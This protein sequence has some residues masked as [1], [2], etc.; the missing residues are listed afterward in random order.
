MTEQQQTTWPAGAP[1]WVDISVTDIGR[2]KDFYTSVLGW[3]FTGGEA[4]FG[5]YTNATLD[6]RAV[7]G[8][9]PPMEGQGEVPNLWT[10]Y[11]AVEDSADVEQQ[12]AAA[13]GSTTMPP[14]QV[15]SFG[16]M[17]IHADPTGAVFGTWQPG[18]HRGFEVTD[19]PGAI[20]WNEAMVGDFER[21]KEFYTQI[22]G[23]T[24]EDMSSEEMQYAIFTTPGETAGRTGGIGKVDDGEQPY[25]SVVF[26][27]EDTD[28]AAQRVTAAGG[29]VS[30]EP[31]DFEFGRLA[32]CAGPDG[33]P[34]GIITDPVEE[35]PV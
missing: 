12:I 6:G 7:A 17:G 10:V 35:Q 15:G 4:E 25:W 3:D 18:G 14:M 24:Y 9:A 22:F 26:K 13:G 21:G 1:A 29:S 33:E 23:W 34:F 20:S 30:V 16:T 27:V 8:M 5:G 19:E 28:A 31:F 11:L 2:S 32:I